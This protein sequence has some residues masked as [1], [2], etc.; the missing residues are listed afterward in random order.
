MCLPREA[1]KLIKLW[2]R[3]PILHS[4][5]KNVAKWPFSCFWANLKRH[6]ANCAP[7]SRN[8][9]VMS[10]ITGDFL[11]SSCLLLFLLFS[12]HLFPFD[13]HMSSSADAT[14]VPSP[15]QPSGHEAETV[16]RKR[17]SSAIDGS[18]NITTA[19]NNTITNSSSSPSVGNQQ[20]LTDGNSSD[21]SMRMYS[22]LCFLVCFYFP[23]SL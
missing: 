6:F 23:P 8:C 5:Y 4:L 10:S 22:L 18:M 21:N 13:G 12:A 3:S 11:S 1:S 14:A 15:S 19:I 17:A 2:Q 9:P 16:F 7:F 20:L